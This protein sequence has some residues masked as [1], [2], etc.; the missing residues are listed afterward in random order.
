MGNPFLKWA[1]GKRKLLDQIEQLLPPDAA[2][3]RYI[4]P[5]LGGGAL[6]FRLKPQ[7]AILNDVNAELVTTYLAV[8]G[9]LGELLDELVPLRERTDEASFYALRCYYNEETLSLCER[10]ALFIYLN[11]TCFNGLYRVNAKGEF[12]VPV[13]RYTNPRVLDPGGLTEASRA[14]AG[15]SIRCGDYQK[16]LEQAQPGDFVYLDPPYA[17]VSKTSSFVGYTKGGFGEREQETLRTMFECLHEHGCVVLLSNS[18]T[19]ALRKLYEGFRITEVSAP[20]AINA[21]KD[22]RGAVTEL[23]ISNY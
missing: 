10:A 1:G 9:R 4:E 11:R 13:G 6:F 2:Q 23:V 18:D 3:R 16:T 22:G 19:P 8:Q 15:V 12:N 5:F 21:K 20:R 17:P 14:L 7:D